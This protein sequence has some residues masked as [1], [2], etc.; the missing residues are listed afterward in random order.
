[1]KIKE[2]KENLLGSHRVFVEAIN[3]MNAQQFSVSPERKWNAGQQLS[4]VLKGLKGVHTGFVR[5]KMQLKLMFGKSDRPSRSYEDLISDYRTKLSEGYSNR[6]AYMPAKV[7][8]GDAQILNDKLISYA[9]RLSKKLNSYKEEEL[10]K[11]QL[12]HPI[13]GKMTLR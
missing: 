9:S 7:S 13:L 4:H 12:P 6:I 11:Y 2:I 5:P 1:M 3:D 10:D 8:F